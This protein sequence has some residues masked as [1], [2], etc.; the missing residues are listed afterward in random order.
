MFGE[1]GLIAD[2]ENNEK[3]ILPN[4]DGE[5]YM[6]KG[7][8]YSKVG[9]NYSVVYGKKGYNA[10]VVYGKIAFNATSNATENL[11]NSLSTLTNSSQNGT[12]QTDN[13]NV[14]TNDEVVNNDGEISNLEDDEVGL[15]VNLI[16]FIN[17][18]SIIKS[19]F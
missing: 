5:Y 15:D 9:Y 11:I 3:V 6:N 13:S 14:I 2:G 16:E 17:E 7:I 10:T 8:E 19:K 4:F 18:W 12:S 1:L